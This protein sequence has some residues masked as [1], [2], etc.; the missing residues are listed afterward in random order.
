MEQ[1]EPIVTL[2]LS[3][4]K[5]MIVGIPYYIGPPLPNHAAWR[6]RIVFFSLSPEIF[7]MFPTTSGK[8]IF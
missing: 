1:Y 5:L 7:Y 3:P 6:F 8:T 4:G 2:F